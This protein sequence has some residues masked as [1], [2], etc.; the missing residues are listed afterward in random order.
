MKAVQEEGMTVSGAAKQFQ[1]PRKTLDDR[2][3]GR[4]EH[5]SRPGPPTA[6]SAEEEGA[7]AAYLLYM[8]EH[9]FPLSS[10]MAMGF[11]WAI[12]VRSG[13]QERFNSETGPG[14]HWWRSFRSRHPELVL[15]TP[16]N[17]ER[18][19]A[20]AFTREV[21]DEYFE[22]LKTTL[23][24]NNLLNAPRQLFNCDETF[25]PLNLACEKVVARKNVKHV[26]T[27]SRG[28]SDHI[29]MLCGASA[30][31]VA[32]P[33]MIIYSKAFPGGLYKFSGPDDAVYAKSESGW[34]DG[35]LY[36][37]WMKKVFLKF[38][39]SQR[40]VLFVD[41]HASHVSL[42]VIDL[43]REN[44]IILFCL[45]P[46]TTH[47]LQPL[48]VSVFKS[49][50]S[51][52]SKAVHSLSLAK[53]DFVVTKRDFACVVKTP[54]ERAFNISN[55]KA[56]FAKC[57]VYPFDPKAIDESKMVQGS[58]SSS[59]SDLTVTPSS[60]AS[61]DES[62]CSLPSSDISDMPS[63]NP[64]PIVS[65]RSSQPAASPH[66]SSP[67][68]TT[69]VVSLTITPPAP[70]SQTVPRVPSTP[71]SRPHVEN[72]LVKAGLIP[73][74]LADILSPQQETDTEKRKSRR[75]TGVRVLTS[76]EY[77]EMMRERDRKEKQAAEMKQKRKEE[78]EQRKE[79]EKERKRK[80]REE[81]KKGDSGRQKKG[82]GKKRSHSSSEESEDEAHPHQAVSHTRTIRAPE[83]YGD[84]SDD[85]SD[86]STTK[87]IICHAREPPIT[88]A[89]VF[90]VDCDRCGEWAHTHCALGSNTA[91]SRFV[92]ATC[93]SS[94][95]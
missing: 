92:C 79:Q 60:C 14:K 17:L 42:D 9:G 50:K 95:T 20:N 51:H 53:R 19:R 5:G 52:F 78:R 77:T 90:W 32:L 59:E 8:A 85:E 38:C 30:A 6:L 89:M 4:V 83:R 71:L 22:C 62:S 93:C 48:D 35:E 55:I 26:Y 54:F 91:S 87:C 40:P 68:T 84:N 29:T 44:D 70:T 7:L 3:K 15:R 64:S 67:V 25:L 58:T 37:A 69:A 49:L 12:S 39:G 28:T 57:G 2:I 46:H 88:E 75:I 27:Q 73:L 94:C 10:N 18:S 80:E 76:N 86:A 82:K 81:K 56:G 21:V 34:I 65:L 43:A 13:T 47:A 23:E 41:G 1:V 33:P 16:D 36:L 31:G 61:L 45:P 24:Q 66:T 72:P 74:H 63:V 11:A